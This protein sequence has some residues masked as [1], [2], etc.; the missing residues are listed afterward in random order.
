M[1]D[2]VCVY[3]Y[4]SDNS[5]LFYVTKDT[6]DR[7]DKV[8]SSYPCILSIAFCFRGKF[9]DVM[10]SVGNRF[11]CMIWARTRRTTTWSMTNWMRHSLCTCIAHAR[12]NICSSPPSPPYVSTALSH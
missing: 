10:I 12:R 6:L 3:V 4:Y 9:S 2:A 11:G 8:H 5:T 7:P 1:T